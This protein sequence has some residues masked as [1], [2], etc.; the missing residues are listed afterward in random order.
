[1]A[2]LADR[3]ELNIEKENSLAEEIIPET[4]DD[5]KDNLIPENENLQSIKDDTLKDTELT[6]EIKPETENIAKNDSSEEILPIIEN[7]TDD[8][9]TEDAAKNITEEYP[10]EPASIIEDAEVEEA[11]RIKP[12]SGITDIEDAE[13]E[14]IPSENTAP[15]VEIYPPFEEMNK[16]SNQADNGTLQNGN[17]NN[18]PQNT[19]PG[20]TQQ[21]A[22][23]AQNNLPLQKRD[24]YTYIPSQENIINQMNPTTPV[25]KYIPSQMGLQ[26]NKTF[27]NSALAAAL[28]RADRAEKRAIDTLAGNFGNL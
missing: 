27:D 8:K 7:S 17:K 28:R 18:T 6:E 26:L 21:S 12:I 1:M 11:D 16:M 5:R 23:K 19:A 22:K 20:Y 15:K 2:A 13:Y 10:A 3:G 9:F 14:E 24:N 25:N 4:I